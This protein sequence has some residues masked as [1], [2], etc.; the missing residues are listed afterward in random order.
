MNFWIVGDGKLSGYERTGECLHC[1]QC[2]ILGNRIH[3][4]FT[5]GATSD[6]KGSDGDDWTMFQH[7]GVWWYFK[8]R[9]EDG[10][11]KACPSYEAPDCLCWQDAETWPAICRYWPMHPNLPLENCGFTFRK[12]ERDDESNLA[13][14]VR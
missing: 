2:C 3:Y 11:P 4:E 12:K 10:T 1:G 8:A 13:Q 6:N 7:H 9:I 14:T 5:V